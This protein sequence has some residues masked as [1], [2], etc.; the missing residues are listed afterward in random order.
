MN[1]IYTHVASTI[2]PTPCGLT[3]SSTAFAISTVNLS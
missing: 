2:T 1:Y 3:A